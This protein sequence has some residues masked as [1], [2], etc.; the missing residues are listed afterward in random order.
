MSSAAADGA[1][2]E[3]LYILGVVGVNIET[4]IHY[5]ENTKEKSGPAPPCGIQDKI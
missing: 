3:R 2:T 1:Q 4:T 5:Y